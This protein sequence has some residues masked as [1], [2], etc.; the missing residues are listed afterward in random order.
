MKDARDFIDTLISRCGS[1][2]DETVQKYK[3]EDDV[4]TSTWKEVDFYK[5]KD[6][7]NSLLL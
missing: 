2:V 6:H 4:D 1:N 5:V 7:G 3:V